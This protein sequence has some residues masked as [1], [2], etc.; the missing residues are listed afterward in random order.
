MGLKLEIFISQGD[1]FH[2]VSLNS[3]LQ[4]LFDE[5]IKAYC[6][7]ANIPL[8]CMI[9]SLRLKGEIIMVLGFRISA[10]V[11]NIWKEK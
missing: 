6:F 7:S 11:V 8:K 9:N 1:F 5:M 10:V 3:I 4:F 2:S